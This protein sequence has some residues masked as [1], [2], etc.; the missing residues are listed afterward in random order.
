MAIGIDLKYTLRLLA[1]NPKFTLMTTLIIAVGLGLAL[2]TFTLLNKLL[3]T[4]IT[5]DDGRE[6]FIIEGSYDNTHLS[7]RPAASVDLYSFKKDTSLIH[8]MGIYQ[9]RTTFVS[10]VGGQNRKYNSSH[11]SYNIFDFANVK[12]ILGRGFVRDDQYDGAEDVIVIGYTMWQQHFG[13]REDIIGDIV[14][15]DGAEPH[16]VIGIM[17]EGFAFPAVAEMWELL[18]E[19]HIDPTERNYDFSAAYVKLADG[20]TMSNVRTALEAKNKVLAMSFNDDWSWII[21]RNGEYLTIEPMKKAHLMQYYGLFVALFIVAL[22]ILIL[23]CINVAN[24]LLARVNERTKEV[25]IRM[26]LGVPQKRLIMQML[27]ESIFICT[28]GGGIALLL[29]GYGLDVTDRALTEIF[30][31][32][33]L[34]PYW[35][36]LS[37]DSTAILAL[38]VTV[39]MMIVLTG[40]VPAWKALHTDFNATLR[41]GTR[42]ALGKKAA[43]IGKTLVVSEILFS[44]VVLVMASVIL[45]STFVASNADYGVE[46]ENRLTASLQISPAEYP[47]RDDEEFNHTDRLKRTQFYYALKDELESYSNINSM[48]YMSQL[49]GT[50]GGT[51]FFEIEGR[52]AERFDENPYSNNEGASHGN[53]SA[54]GME[55]I[56]GRDFDYRDAEQGA[57]SIIVNES[58]ANDFFPDGEAVGKRVRRANPDSFGDW[59]TIIGVVSDT[60]HGSK[61]DFSSAQYNTYHSMDNWGMFRLQLAIHYN[62]TEANARASLYQALEKTDPKVGL[63]RIQSYDE[64]IAQ[65]LLIIS[66]VST[67]FLVC[68]VVA[69]ILAASGIY[70]VASN[71]IQQRTQEIGVRRAIGSPDRNIMVMFLKQAGWQ[72]LAGIIVGIAVSLW[73]MDTM[74]STMVFGSFAF[75]FAV[76]IMPTV[77]VTM[78]LFATY[79]PTQRILSREPADALHY[80]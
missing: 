78:V 32:D 10:E 57:R 9:G 70:A 38:I 23:A 71:G 21:G 58:I 44:C 53:W 26:A 64:L 31:L 13:G 14:T 6:I 40:L 22:L 79:L 47:I 72:L 73:L 67:I 77:I 39:V 30:S 29:A 5:F 25:A 63:H 48:I 69:A 65:P 52:P 8:D 28:I 56:A 3:F 59:D 68:G 55:I 66:T 4:P 11:V 34:K 17:P 33:R 50:G 43:N 46:T 45:I 19:R 27:W 75:W 16:K 74:S 37:L 49:P 42:G 12:P 60:Y 15:I 51:S 7:R 2:Y 36:S 41:D 76:I 61:M 62:G 24:L 35:W 20:V 54:L 80:Y 18:P 1:K